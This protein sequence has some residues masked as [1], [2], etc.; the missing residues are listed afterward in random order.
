MGMTRQGKRVPKYRCRAFNS[1][2]IGP[3][4]HL[5]EKCQKAKR[6]IKSQNSKILIYSLLKCGRYALAAGLISQ[7]Q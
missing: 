5:V 3:D 7:E 6:C 2:E 1:A 4:D